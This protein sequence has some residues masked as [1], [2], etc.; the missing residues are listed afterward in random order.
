VDCEPLGFLFEGA[1]HI[2]IERRNVVFQ[3]INGLSACYPQH[4]ACEA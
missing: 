3:G 4:V 1:F 2:E